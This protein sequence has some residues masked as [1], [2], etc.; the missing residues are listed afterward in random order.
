VSQPFIIREQPQSTVPVL[1]YL[2]G[3]WTQRP[4]MV[5]VYDGGPL[6]R[7]MTGHRTGDTNVETFRVVGFGSTLQ[8]AERRAERGRK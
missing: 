1:R 5:P 4:M 2:V 3:Y 6:G 8:R 7:Q